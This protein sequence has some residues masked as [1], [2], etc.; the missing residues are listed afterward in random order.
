MAQQN[1]SVRVE[2]QVDVDDDTNLAR[3]R[4]DLAER[5]KTAVL[6][7]PGTRLVLVHSATVLRRS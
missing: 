6:T 7:Y 5:A 1:L 3:L 4:D 2:V